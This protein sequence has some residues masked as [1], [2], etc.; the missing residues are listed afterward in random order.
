MGIFS[1]NELKGNAEILPKPTKMKGLFNLFLCLCSALFL[2]YTPVSAQNEN[3]D[4]ATS[5]DNDSVL[6]KVYIGK[7]TAFLAIN[8]DSSIHYFLRADDI[9]RMY[10]RYDSDGNESDDYGFHRIAAISKFHLGKLY[11]NRGKWSVSLKILLKSQEHYSKIKDTV[12]VSYALLYIGWAY[13]AK[14]DLER[15]YGYYQEA[16]KNFENPEHKEGMSESL[17]KIGLFY[18]DR[19]ELDRAY[20]FY[21][22]SMDIV[23]TSV[24]MSRLTQIYMR[25]ADVYV[26]QYDLITARENLNYGI[27]TAMETKQ[28]L[29]L[30]TALEKLADIEVEEKRLKQGLGFYN[31]ALALR[32]TLN[33]HKGMIYTL[34]KI[35]AVETEGNNP[36]EAEIAA[37]KALDIANNLENPYWIGI[38]ADTLSEIYRNGLKWEEAYRMFRLYEDN[39]EIIEEEEKA[40]A[41][42]WNRLMADLEMKEVADSIQYA[43]NQEVDELRISEKAAVAEADSFKQKEQRNIFIFIIGGLFALAAIAFLIFKIRQSKKKKE[44]QVTITQQLKEQDKEQYEKLSQIDKLKD[45]YIASTSHQLRTPLEGI[46]GL[47]D[48]MIGGASGELPPKVKSDLSIIRNSSKRLSNLVND[49][50]DFSRLKNFQLTLNKKPVDLYTTVEVVLVTMEPYVAD[51]DLKL[52]NEIQPNMESVLAD[53]IRVEQILS[54]LINNGIKFTEKGSVTISAKHIRNKIAVTVADTGVGI[55]PEQLENLFSPFEKQENQQDMTAEGSGLGLA[56][57]QQLVD[58]HMGVL[59]VES[60]V[61]KGSEFTFTLPVSNEKA[62]KREIAKRQQDVIVDYNPNED[63]NEI[64]KTEVSKKDLKDNKNVRILI[65]DDEIINLQVL[66]NYLKMQGY[67]VIKA[68]SGRMSL[69]LIRDEEPFDLII[70]DVIM[71]KMSGYEVC[72]K[73]REQYQSSELPVILL[74]SKGNMTDL[75]RGFNLGANDYLIKPFSKDELLSRVKTQ[76]NLHKINSATSKFVPFEFVHSLGR[77]SIA[78]VQLGDFIRK[79]VT[80]LFADIRNY[81]TYSEKMTPEQN[82]AYVNNFNAMMGPIISN[83]NGFINQYLGDAI[84]AVFPVKPGDAVRASIEMQ[85]ATKEREIPKVNGNTFPIK[86]GIGMHTGEMVMGITGDKNRFEATTISDSVN[87][88][89]RLEGLTKYYGNSI[90]LSDRSMQLVKNKDEFNFRYL[91]KVKV[92][93]KD[94]STGIYECFDGDEKQIRERKIATN[95]TFKKGL[96]LFFNK[97]FPEATV[98]FQHVLEAN[99]DDKTARLFLNKSAQMISQGVPDGWE[100]VDLMSGK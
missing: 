92:M 39:Q 24:N 69:D 87:I 49:L 7:A 29:D 11:Q 90:L 21:Q 25:I 79:E 51:K 71:P 30:A 1:W 80:V 67:S 42:A 5:S 14:E 9:A 43:L 12:G 73:I 2:F 31:Q 20:A 94:K 35:S 3:A 6:A 37:L 16:L 46:I 76:L 52:I 44:G 64:G 88:A 28:W 100:G 89:A 23:D 4:R 96:E 74:T 58:R 26:K 41:L 33:D 85:K 17:E 78:E 72:E 62:E 34:L 45:Q 97:S 47:A 70:L 10:F 86:V 77:D 82:F 18:E 22:E 66:E 27:S 81:T 54:N 65:A 53:E 36:E 83:N 55:P 98:A 38:T 61:G 56:I 50:I 40:E 95:S 99:S 19:A 15:A 13:H 59:T 68:S 60:T 32:D 8:T 57:A 48:T 84:M 75:V 91:G 93:G 63:G